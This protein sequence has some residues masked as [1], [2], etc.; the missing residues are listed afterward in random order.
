MA[1]SVASSY[2][3]SGLRHLSGLSRL[4][5]LNLQQCYSISDEHIQLLS[6]LTALTDLTANWLLITGANLSA[7]T[8]LCA[9]R[10]DYCPKVAAA[11]L[12]SIAQLQ[13]LRQ[14]SLRGRHRV[15]RATELA[16]LSQLTNLEELRVADDWIEGT[17]LALLD[18]PR[19]TSLEAW[20]IF[21]EQHEPSR[22]A[23][24]LSLEL[25]S[26]QGMPLGQLLPL[27]SLERLTIHRAYGDLSAVGKQPQLTHLRLGGL[28]Y[29]SGWRLAGVLPELQRLQLL[30]L[31]R[32]WGWL[33]LEHMLAL[34]QLPLLEE[35][36]IDYC[37]APDELYCLLQHCARLRKVVLQGCSNVG[38]PALMALVSKAGMREV[39][40]G[41]I[42]GAEEHEER[43]KRV[44]RRLGVQLTVT[45]E[46][47][48]DSCLSDAEDDYASTEEGDESEDG[49]D[50]DADAEMEGE[51]QDG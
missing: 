22:G 4:R 41:G 29:T 26:N 12:A 1:L 8:S 40:L 14:L 33:E 32:V 47:E 36:C 17:A 45:G 11:R 43:L 18:L 46:H 2:V 24:I 20:R 37:D 38:L 28:E 31:S 23:A 34:A 42:A 10:L 15:R 48:Y 7:L 5:E 13:Q 30:H 6:A 19:L 44:A 51:E 25:R 16:P 21:A 35:V 39:E 49:L 3:S 27:P 9:L 50:E